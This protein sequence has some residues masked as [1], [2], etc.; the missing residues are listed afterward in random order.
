MELGN[1]TLPVPVAL[2]LVALFGYL[3]GRRPWNRGNQFA[4]RS[5]REVQR[6]QR[7][8]VELERIVQ[9]VR[10]QLGEHQSSLSR[11]KDRVARLGHRQQETTWK[12]LCREVEE[13]LKPTLQLAAQIASAYDQI[14]QQT[15]SLMSFTEVRTDPLTGIKNRRGLEDAM[16]SHFALMNR[17]GTPFA[18]AIFDIDNFRQVNDRLG[19]L[20]GDRMLHELAQLLIEQVRETDIVGRY[21]GEE[22]LVIM[23]NTDL[24]SACV[25]SER[26]RAATEERMELTISGGVVLASDGDTRDSL[27]DR[28]DRALC[29][30]K[31]GGGNRVYRHTGDEAEPATVEAAVAEQVPLTTPRVR[32]GVC[33]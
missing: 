18:L 28:A 6:A 11:F 17:Y 20:H 33:E 31:S 9:D 16:V 32:D 21:G 19:V 29:A 30:A 14:R 15:A 4:A 2:A 7:V 26:L 12:E 10:R 1:I 25:F 23:P 13:I 24:E 8:A 27:L 5:E 22:F 3:I